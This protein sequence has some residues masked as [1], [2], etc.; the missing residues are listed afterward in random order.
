M[1]QEKGAFMFWETYPLAIWDVN[2]GNAHSIGKQSGKKIEDCPSILYKGK[3][4]CFNF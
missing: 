2:I 1:P 4:G 3:Y